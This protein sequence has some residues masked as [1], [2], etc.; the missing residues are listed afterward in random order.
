MPLRF[1]D[2]VFDRGARELRRGGDRVALTPKAFRFLELVLERRPEAVSRA[3]L[4]DALWPDTHVSVASLARVATDLRKA[5]GDDARDPRYIRTLHGFGYVFAGEAGDQE[6]GAPG[7]DGRA[8]R[9]VWGG[10]EIPMVEGPNVIGR[11]PD[12]AIWID[13]TKVSRHHAQIVVAGGRATLEDLGSK[14]GTFLR[15]R[16]LE[17]PAELSDGDLIGVGSA[18]FRF[19]CPR[20]LASTESDL[21]R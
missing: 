16:R 21:A 10:R 4:H 14:N 3:E 20:A 19:R 2:C 9:L 12:A 15:G 11:A 7:S 6:E 18:V 13:S 1:G 17:A 5:L 8:C